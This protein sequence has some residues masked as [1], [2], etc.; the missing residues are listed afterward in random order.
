MLTEI[1]YYS[2][3]A[4]SIV[5]AVRAKMP[6]SPED[7]VLQKLRNRAETFLDV[8]NRVIFANPK[9]PYAEMFRLAGCAFGDLS[10]QVRTEGLEAALLRLRREGIYL[11]HNEWKGKTPIV[12]SGREIAGSTPSFK[13]PLVTG[14]ADS[15]SSGTTGRPVASSKS[16]ETVIHSN[17]YHQLR[18][19]EFGLKDRVWIDLKPILPAR[20]G[21]NN[22]LRG[23]QMGTPVKRWFSTGSPLADGHYRVMTRAMVALG[24]CMGARAPYPTYLPPNDFEPVAEYVA[25]LRSEGHPAIV[26]GFASP[27]VRVAAVALEKGYDISGT[28]FLTSGEAVTAA[29]RQILEKAGTKV[30][31]VYSIGEVGHVGLAC[32]QTTTNGVHLLSDSMAVIGFGRPAPFNEDVQVNSLHFTTLTP[33]SSNVFIN[34]EMDDDGVIEE[35]T[36]D[37]VFSRLGMKTRINHINSFAKMTPQGITF[38]TSV[39]IEVIEQGLPGRLGGGPGDYQL[40]EYEGK[41]QTELRLHVS[42]RTGVTDLARVRST[43]LELMRPHFAG[44]LGTREWRNS[45]GVEVRIAEPIATGTGKVHPIRLLGAARLGSLRNSQETANAS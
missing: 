45:N 6:A 7:F 9:H 32:S 5:Q 41:N 33:Y 39:L 19:Q 21:I 10:Q 31:P 20:Q 34:V 28:I 12:R 15:F 8:A 3:M 37:C 27:V 42:P 36:C 40:I 16:I 13:N 43:F 2:R 24:N 29:K 38:H 23:R 44:A 14:W 11:S 25:R 18:S 26:Q 1:R 4:V 30:F 17:V 35:C 22:V